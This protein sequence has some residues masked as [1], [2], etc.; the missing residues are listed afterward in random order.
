LPPPKLK[1]GGWNKKEMQ[2]PEKQEKIPVLKPDWK[3]HMT[4]K[5]KPQKNIS[6][7]SIETA[8]SLQDLTRKI[9][10]PVFGEKP[11]NDEKHKK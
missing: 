8:I 4:H 6:Q 5:I 2:I 11:L 10:S 7:S 1:V 9:P 3:D